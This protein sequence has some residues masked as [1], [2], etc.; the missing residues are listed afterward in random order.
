MKPERRSLQRSPAAFP[1]P[2]ERHGS[3]VARKRTSNALNLERLLRFS[4]Q[5]YAH[6]LTLQEVLRSE[7]KVAYEV[8]HPR[9]NRQAARQFEIFY[10][11]LERSPK[12]RKPEGSA[13]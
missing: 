5:L 3:K 9:Y 6:A 2:I 8:L 13:E 1:R 11:S 4:Q 7:G 10:H 12:P